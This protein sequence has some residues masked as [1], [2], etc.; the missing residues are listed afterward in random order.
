MAVL[1]ATQ[2]AIYGSAPLHIVGENA[3]DVTSAIS[4]TPDASKDI[5]DFVNVQA[6]I[7]RVLSQALAY[8]YMQGSIAQLFNKQTGAPRVVLIHPGEDIVPETCMSFAEV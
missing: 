6:I 1:R 4:G 5:P 8:P 3:L 2:R 7:A